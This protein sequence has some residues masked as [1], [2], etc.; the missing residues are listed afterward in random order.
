MKKALLVI[1]VQNDMFQEE[2]AVHNGERLLQN[3]KDLIAQA[4]SSQTP[5]A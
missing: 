4:R 1:D 2:N 3:L 5:V